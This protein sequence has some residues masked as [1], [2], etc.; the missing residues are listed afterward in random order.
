MWVYG[1]RNKSTTKVYIY[2]YACEEKNN[3]QTQHLNS[4]FI[5]FKSG[6]KKKTCFLKDN[7][8]VY[9]TNQLRMSFKD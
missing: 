1:R 5:R 8:H 2:D 4:E 9:K 6:F 3:I 7:K